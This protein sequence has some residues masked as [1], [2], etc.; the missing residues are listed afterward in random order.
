M[1]RNGSISP[2]D[3]QEA[4]V[5]CL[6]FTDLNAD[7][8][9]LIFRRFDRSHTGLLNFADFSRLMLPFSYEYA[10][11]ITDRIDFYSRQNCDASAFWSSETR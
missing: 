9:Q 5:R 7:D 8:V 2:G 10:S 3:I 1:R 6:S 11:L 4:L